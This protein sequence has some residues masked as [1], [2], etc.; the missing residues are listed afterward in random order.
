VREAF[1]EKHDAV[2]QTG[3]KC[4]CLDSIHISHK[5]ARFRFLSYS[6]GDRPE[7]I[8]TSDLSIKPNPLGDDETFLSWTHVLG[9]ALSNRYVLIIERV[10][11][12]IWPS[13]IEEYFQWMIDQKL[14]APKIRKYVAERSV[15][16]SIEVEPDESFMRRV[17]AMDRIMSAMLRIVRPNPGWKDLEKE[18]GGEA[19]ESDAHYAEVKMNA[20]RNATLKKSEGI[21]KAMKDMASQKQLGRAIVEGKVDGETEVVSS[22]RTGRHQYKYLPTDPNGNIVVDKVFDALGRYLDTLD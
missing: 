20:R 8:D 12:G 6:E 15:T 21:I 16:V 5:R 2:H 11:T 13:R 4:H 7:V 18:L 19:D 17:L 9:S 14:S 10:Q 1:R 3:K 22:E